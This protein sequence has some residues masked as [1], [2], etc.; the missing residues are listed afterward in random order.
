MRTHLPALLAGLLAFLLVSCIEGEEE[1]WLKP[2]GS[3]RI[4]ATYKM[5]TA[6]AQKITLE[7]LLQ[8]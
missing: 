7:G 6:V 2:D 4:Q 8:E 5:P 3:G 1:I